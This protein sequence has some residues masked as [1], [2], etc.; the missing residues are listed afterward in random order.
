L[1]IKTIRFSRKLSRRVVVKLYNVFETT[2]RDKM[3]DVILKNDS[4]LSVQLLIKIKKDVII[5]YILDLD[6]REFSLLINDVRELINYI[7]ESRDSR[8]VGKQ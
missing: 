7:L 2:L 4:R 8:R 1:T 3:N 6:S 5:Q